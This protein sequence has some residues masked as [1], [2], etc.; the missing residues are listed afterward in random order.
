[1]VVSDGFETS[2]WRLWVLLG[3]YGSD[4]GGSWGVSSELVSE[5]S[6]YTHTYIHIYIY[7]IYIYIYI[8]GCFSFVLV[9]AE[10]ARAPSDAKPPSPGYLLQPRWDSSVAAGGH[11][12]SSLS[13]AGPAAFRILPGHARHMKT[14]S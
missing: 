13:L 6:R 4:A 11:A 12:L 1:M 2:S 3:P 8:Y 14:N 9:M 5:Q 10:L 7:I